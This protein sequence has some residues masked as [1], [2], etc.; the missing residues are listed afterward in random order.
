MLN[1]KGRYKGFDSS[2]ISTY[3]LRS[4]PSKFDRENMLDPGDLTSGPMDLTIPQLAEVADAV[5]E[6][7]WSDQPVVLFAGAH[8]IK[9]GFGLLV[10]DLMERSIITMI[11]F[12]AAGVIHDLEL[13]LVGTTS[14]DV[15]QGLPRG[16]F[17]FAEETGNLINRAFGHG[18]RLGLGAGEAVA[19]LILGEPFP[20]KVEFPYVEK[21]ILA[22]AYQ[23]G[24]P[25]T[26]HA[27]I[28]TDIVDQ[29]PSFDP[30]AKGACSGRDF[31]IFC[32]EIE[33]MSEGGVFLNVGSAVTGPEVFL[34]ACSMCANVGHPP[35][36]IIT[37]SF[38]F[39]PAEASDESDERRPGYYFR[40]LKSV[41][42]RVPEAFGGRGYYIQGDHLDTVPALYQ[43]LI[44]DS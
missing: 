7:R 43:H 36:G 18:N 32:A 27:T 11:S 40:D 15:R 42:V 39:R 13:A 9:N 34:K 37:A 3:S 28:G 5:R 38:D 1:Y 24:I 25:A 26:V 23:A 12:N 4:R 16:E 35:Q 20:E 17:G 33:R 21:S 10:R 19:R 22:G 8:L 14:E 44:R 31:L 30:G 29:V 41:V 2:R 6:A